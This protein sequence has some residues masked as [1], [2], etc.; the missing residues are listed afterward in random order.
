MDVVSEDVSCFGAG[1]GLVDAVPLTGVFPIEYVLSGAVADTNATGAFDDLGARGVRAEC[2]R[3]QWLC[4]RRG[5][6]D[7]PRA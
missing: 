3:R 7:H 1:D 4:G 5:D 2:D 6:A